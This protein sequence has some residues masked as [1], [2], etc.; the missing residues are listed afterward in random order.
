MDGRGALATAL[1][2]MATSPVKADRDAI[3]RVEREC[4]HDVRNIAVLLEDSEIILLA[5]QTEERSKP[6]IIA[7]GI[8]W[9]GIIGIAAMLFRPTL[10]WEGVTL[11]FVVGS[12]SVVKSRN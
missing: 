6:K 11:G 4:Q 10:M 1:I 12:A 5:S 7:T 9:A 2:K 8:F 3:A